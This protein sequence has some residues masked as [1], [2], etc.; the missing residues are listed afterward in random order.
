MADIPELV[1]A[2]MG[3]KPV[4]PS[5][6]GEPP[7]HAKAGRRDTYEPALAQRMLEGK[8]YRPRRTGKPMN[9]RAFYNEMYGA[10]GNVRPHYEPYAR[11]LEG[12]T[13]EQLLQ[14]QPKKVLKKLQIN[15]RVMVWNKF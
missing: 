11:W 8:E 5:H 1:Q 12:Q 4:S 9:R 10:D 13:V 14:K 2:P 3:R 15:I 7:R 6:P